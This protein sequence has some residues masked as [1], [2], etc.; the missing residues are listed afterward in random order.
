MPDIYVVDSRDNVATAMTD[1]P[2]GPVNR[3]GAVAD[4][5]LDLLQPLTS[6]H[7]AAL[8]DIAPGDAIIKYGA[9]IGIARCAAARGEWIHVHNLKSM[10]DERSANIDAATSV[11]M[12]TPYE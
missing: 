2:K 1:L 10:F 5:E 6:G 7:K 8:R 12:D 4:G 9:V 11:A 3:I